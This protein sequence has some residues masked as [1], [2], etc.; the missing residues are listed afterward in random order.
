MKKLVTTGLFTLVFLAQSLAPPASAASLSVSVSFFRAEL[1]PF[2]TWVDVPAWG[3]VWRPDDVGPGWQPYLVGHWAYTSHGWTWISQ[4]PWDPWP[5]HYGTWV[6]TASHGWVW[7]PGTVWAP[8]WVTWY[9]TDRYVGWCPVPPSLS[10]SLSGVT[11]ARH[12]APVDS[13]VFVPTR[14]FAT[15]EIRSARVDRARNRS[16][17][18]SAEALP[19]FSV[20][21]GVVRT[22][23]PVPERIER[24]AGVS[25]RRS[26]VS[27]ARV[28]P[29]R[30]SGD[31]LRQRR[32][33][34][35]VAPRTVRESARQVR[36]SRPRPSAKAGDRKTWQAPGTREVRRSEPAGPGIRNPLASKPS[37]RSPVRQKPAER[38]RKGKKERPAGGRG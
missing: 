20:V 7:V 1:E 24:Q 35:V 13:V 25:V 34:P 6:L 3:V 26:G 8:A 38:D 11:R 2:G 12:A 28:R 30:L 32:A 31:L 29:A 5:Y 22:V 16:L 33:A 17:L 4:D 15:G 21:D 19:S 37:T 18:R 23:G 27:A 10:V 36:E 14:A 9:V